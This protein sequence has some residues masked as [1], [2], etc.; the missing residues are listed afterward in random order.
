MKRKVSFKDLVLQNKTEILRDQ[1]TL[2]KIE[3]KI[4]KKH[5]LR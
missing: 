4:D 3:A 1:E 2:E 5:S